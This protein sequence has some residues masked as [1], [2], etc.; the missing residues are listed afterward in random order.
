MNQNTVI[1][2]SDSELDVWDRYAAAALGGYLSKTGSNST[3]AAKH[4]AEAAD[5]MIKERRVREDT[6]K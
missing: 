4:A 1:A 3:T 6:L 2:L 5:S